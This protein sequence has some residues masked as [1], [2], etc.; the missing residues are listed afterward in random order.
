MYL[1]VY[2]CMYASVP[3]FMNVYFYVLV[4]MCITLI[5]LRI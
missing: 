4:C 1:Y 5:E 2:S 3:V